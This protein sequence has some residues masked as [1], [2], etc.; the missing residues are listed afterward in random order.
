MSEELNSEKEEIKLQADELKK[1]L[2]NTEISEDDKAELIVSS[3]TA[4][5]QSFSGPI[6]PPEILSHYDDVVEN[7]AERIV[8]MAEKQSDHRMDLEKF[9]IKR[10]I[11]QSG[12]GQIFGFVIALLCI[13]STIFLAL[14][15]YET[16][17]IALGTTTVLG[18]AS[19]FVLG[20]ILQ[21]KN[22]DD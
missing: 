8:R 10:Q 18:L 6:P 4:V 7:G 1:I 15:G 12:R 9:A 22:K 16:L 11:T 17:A 13:G 14:K 19:I 20:K 3:I 2:K 21:S 5:Q